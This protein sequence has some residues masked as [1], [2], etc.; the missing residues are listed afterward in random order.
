MASKTFAQAATSNSSP[1]GSSIPFHALD[2]RDPSHPFF[3]GK[4][5]GGRAG[6]DGKFILKD[7]LVFD[8]TV[9]PDFR[10]LESDQPQNT[11]NQRFEVFFPEKRPFFQEGANYFETPINMYFTR[12]IANPQFGVRVTGKLGPYGI[13]VLASD[14]QSPGLIVPDNDPLHGKRAYFTVGRLT[15]ELWKQ[16]QIGIY[17]SDREMDAVPDSL[18]ATNAVNTTEQIACVS[19]SNR[20]GGPD[21]TFHFGDHLQIRGQALASATDQINQLHFA[22]SLFALTAEYTSRHISYTLDAR[23]ITSGFV[24]LMGFYQRPDIRKATN[25]LSYLFRPEGAIV[26]SWGPRMFQ[27]TTYDHAGNQLDAIYEPSININL[28]KNTNISIYSGHWRELLRPSDYSVLTH[29]ADFNK[30][31]YFGTSVTSSY[32]GWMSVNANFFT[33]KNINFRSAH[34]PAARPRKRNSTGGR[35]DRPPIQPSQHRQRLHLGTPHLA[36]GTRRHHQ[37]SR[38][39][40]EVELPIQQAAVVPGD[41]AI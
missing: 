33:G 26:T 10:Q 18:C 13:G 32:L 12:R 14:D 38:R 4:N 6:L 40:L 7:S 35:N 27:R 24:T 16:S 5:L 22:G 28:R 9:N 8:F 15:R 21:F 37:L 39:A 36:H 3:T 31:D 30:G 41:R 1:T 25:T 11:V 29:N 34:Q 2:Q 23:D 19:R 17:Y 20:V